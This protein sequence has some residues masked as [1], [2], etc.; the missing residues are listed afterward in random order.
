MEDIV[1]IISTVVTSCVEV[2]VE[3]FHT[4]PFRTCNLVTSCVEVWVETSTTATKPRL[5]ICHLLRGGVG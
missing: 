5:P 2:W 4:K 1:S 3:T